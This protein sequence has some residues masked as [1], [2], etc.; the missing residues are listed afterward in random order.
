MPFLEHRILVCHIMLWLC[1]T[2]IGGRAKQTLCDCFHA[3]HSHYPH[4]SSISTLVSSPVSVPLCSPTSLANHPSSFSPPILS[5]P[6]FPSHFPPCTL[7]LY[8]PSHLFSILFTSA[9]LLPLALHSASP[10]P[11]IL[12]I[13]YCPLNSPPIVSYFRHWFTYLS[14]MVSL[15]IYNK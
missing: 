15:I 2:L 5:F 1:S 7:H 9:H 6:Y 13:P 4:V 12:S 10:S 11:P 3:F 8:F 14:H